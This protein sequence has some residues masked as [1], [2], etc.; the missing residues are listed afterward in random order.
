MRIEVPHRITS[1]MVLEIRQSWERLGL[2]SESQ[3]FQ[4]HEFL[5][6]VKDILRGEGVAKVQ[7]P[8]GCLW[9]MGEFDSIVCD[10]HAAELWKEI[11]RGGKKEMA[12]GREVQHG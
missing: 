5:R 3:G 1:E 4:I 10:K 12:F 11:E 2:S 8:C 7:P 9:V 6:D